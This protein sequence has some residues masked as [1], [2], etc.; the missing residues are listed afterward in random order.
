MSMAATCP[1]K[2]FQVFRDQKLLAGGCRRVGEERHLGRAPPPLFFK[3]RPFRSSSYMHGSCAS[4]S[5][6]L[7][8]RPYSVDTGTQRAEAE[9]GV[10]LACPYTSPH[11]CLH[12]CPYE[13]KPD[14]VLHSPTPHCATPCHATCAAPRWTGPAAHTHIGY[15]TACRPPVLAHAAP[16]WPQRCPE[17]SAEPAAQI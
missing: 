6:W 3:K 1:K 8:A 5:A 9:P 14:Q 7:C 15:A 10:T 2:A 16:K 17:C 4:P 11:S 12:T 13:Q